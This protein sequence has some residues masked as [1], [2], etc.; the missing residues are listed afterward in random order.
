MPHGWTIVHTI[1]ESVC[2]NLE[3]CLESTTTVCAQLLLGHGE[4]SL[5]TSTVVPVQYPQ[6]QTPS[7]MAYPTVCMPIPTRGSQ[8]TVE[9]VFTTSM[10]RRTLHAFRT[11]GTK[12]C[13]CQNINR[14][15]VI[16]FSKSSH[17]YLIYRR[18]L[19]RVALQY[20]LCF[21]LH[22]GT[23]QPVRSKHL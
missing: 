16:R 4:Y 23:D 18:G 10:P 14:V 8:L 1:S 20:L 11:I 13:D 2:A 6:L 5:S 7:D 17:T 9:H 21:L 12:I 19:L 15:E 3:V 22:N